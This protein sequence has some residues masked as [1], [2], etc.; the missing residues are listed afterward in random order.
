M[1]EDGSEEMAELIESGEWF[2][3]KADVEVP[4]TGEAPIDEAPI[5]E[6][7]EDE[8]PVKE[9]DITKVEDEELVATWELYDAEMARRGFF[10]EKKEE[11]DAIDLDA[12]SD[13]ELKALAQKHG[14]KG[15][16]SMKRE[17]LITALKGLPNA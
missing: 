9:F 2:E 3:N 12:L 6:A 10:E 7:P 15:F 17:T 11:G 1:V 16:G 8:A 5:N 14:V 13:S 4:T